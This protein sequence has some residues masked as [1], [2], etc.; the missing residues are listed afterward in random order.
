M[1]CLPALLLA[2][3]A[4]FLFGGCAHERPAAWRNTTVLNEPFEKA[5]NSAI[6][7]AGVF[8]APVTANLLEGAIQTGEIRVEMEDFPFEGF[9]TE[10]GVFHKW[11]PRRFNARYELRKLSESQTAVSVTCH[12]SAYSINIGRWHSWPS[13]GKYE[14]F[15]VSDLR[16]RLEGESRAAS[17]Q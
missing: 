4:A 17:A 8:G 14:E 7:Y 11:G 9:A 13:N 15:L 5:W 3:C 2:A 1:R 16:S 10:P 12:F 6:D